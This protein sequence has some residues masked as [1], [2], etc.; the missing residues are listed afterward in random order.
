MYKKVCVTVSVIVS[1]WNTLIP[2][3]RHQA[4]RGKGSEPQ[5]TAL[6]FSVENTNASFNSFCLRRNYTSTFQ[7]PCEVLLLYLHALKE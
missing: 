4:L 7:R 3:T 6:D 2:H 1:L 5:T